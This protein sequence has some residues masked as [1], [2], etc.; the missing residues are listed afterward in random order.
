MGRHP[1]L[2][3][4]SSGF[5]HCGANEHRQKPESLAWGT[6]ELCWPV[7]C[8]LS[9]KGS[10]PRIGS[11]ILQAQEELGSGALFPVCGTGASSISPALSFRLLLP[12]QQAWGHT[13]PFSGHTRS[14]SL[15][16]NNLVGLRWNKRV[17]GDSNHSASEPGSP[18]PP[19]PDPSLIFHLGL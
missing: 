8:P 14:S 4:A 18:C 1:G 9:Q 15:R 5:G 16:G 12:G 6:R 19:L 17:R 11:G 13:S 7:S 10:E 3:K 2:G